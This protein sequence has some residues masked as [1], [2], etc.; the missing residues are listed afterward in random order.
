[1]YVHC[2]LGH[3]RTGTVV[4]AYLLAAGKVSDVREGLTYMRTLRPG[5][6]LQRPQRRVL[7]RFAE[8]LPGRAG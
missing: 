8:Q 3:N 5:V 7:E 6:S 2:A 4:L 1:V